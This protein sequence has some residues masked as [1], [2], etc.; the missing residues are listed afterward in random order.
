LVAVEGDLMDFGGES[1]GVVAEGVLDGTE[2]LV[3]GRVGEGLGH[4]ACPLVQERAESIHQLP[5]PGLAV[6]SRCGYGA[7][8]VCHDVLTGG[9]LIHLRESGRRPCALHLHSPDAPRACA[10]TDRRNN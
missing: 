10:L 9:D 2:D 4:L 8:G 5:D 3:G 6:F 1:V 7:V